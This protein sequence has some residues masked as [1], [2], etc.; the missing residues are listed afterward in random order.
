MITVRATTLESFRLYFD[1]DCDFITVDEMEARLLGLDTKPDAEALARMERG[2]AFHAAVERYE[3]GYEPSDREVVREGE[4]AFAAATIRDARAGL[5]GAAE[6]AGSTVLDVGGVSVLL[7]GH[8][9]W[10]L[11][12]QGWDIKTSGKPIPA[13]RHAGSMQ[14][15]AYCLLFGLQR[16]TYR[17]A[18]LADDRQGVVYARSIEDVTVYPYPRMRHDVVACLRDLL[19]FAELRGCLDAME[20]Q[21]AGA[22]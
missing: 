21:E 4:Y 9:D 13:D 11:G 10:L 18:Y 19:A 14:W 8:A 12:L 7:T 16:F 5:N 20:D 17:H 22:A 3:P 6:V 1:P 15:R 2:S